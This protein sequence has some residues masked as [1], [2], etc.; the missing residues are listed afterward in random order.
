MRKNQKANR[1]KSNEIGNYIARHQADRAIYVNNHGKISNLFATSGRVTINGTPVQNESTQQLNVKV[2]KQN[3]SASKSSKQNIPLT[4]NSTK[5]I[6]QKMVFILPIV[7]L[8]ATGTLVA[9]TLTQ[10]R[11]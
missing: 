4:K 6:S 8:L 11:A 7:A 9:K 2:D 1:H 5:G 3:A 10:K